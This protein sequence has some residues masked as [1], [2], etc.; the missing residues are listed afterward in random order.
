MKKVLI[1][2]AIVFPL[3]SCTYLK[4][5]SDNYR[6][7]KKPHNVVLSDANLP[8]FFQFVENR[9][10]LNIPIYKTNNSKQNKECVFIYDTGSSSILQ[11]TIAEKLNAIQKKTTSKKWHLHNGSAISEWPG[12]AINVN[13]KIGSHLFVKKYVKLRKNSILKKV[14]TFQVAGLIGSDMFQ[15]MAVKIDFLN[16]HLSILESKRNKRLDSN[17]IKLLPTIFSHIPYIRCN[18]YNKL[19]T[20]CMLDTGNPIS[21]VLMYN[22]KNHDIIQNILKELPENQK[23]SYSGF[24]GLSNIQHDMFGK[25]DGITYEA[26]LDSINLGYQL[27][28]GKINILFI[29]NNKIK[30]FDCNIGNGLLQY[31]NVTLDYGSR[32]LF[33]TQQK[34][35]QDTLSKK[36]LM[37]SGIAPY[38]VIMYR[39]DIKIFEK[40]QVDDELIS[41]NGIATNIVVGKYTTKGNG[42]LFNSGDILEFK[43]QH[44]EIYQITHP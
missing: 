3:H 32:K 4:I 35:I 26:I 25:K 17:S 22:S 27:I 36:M 38:K 28:K 8:I 23:Q 19:F 42:K 21:V 10:L 31:F 1:A 12:S 34:P 13:Y 39:S 14:D 16:N 33:L 37:I 29:E 9:I 40:I 30:N 24:S 15:K 11:E 5:I 41:I 20:R 7:S 2:L 18:I 6:Y 44:G 43:N